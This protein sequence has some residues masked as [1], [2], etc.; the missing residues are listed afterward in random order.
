MTT[1]TAATEQPQGV[2]PASWLARALGFFS[3]TVGLVVK[4]VLLAAMN[5][6]ALYAV[7]VLVADDRWVAGVLVAA[8]TVLVDVIYLGPWHRTVPLKFLVPGTIFLIGFQVI[9]LISNVNIA[10]TNWSTGHNLN[11][12]EAIAAIEENSLTPPPNGATYTMA[13]ARSANGDLVLL[14]VD[15]ETGKHYVGTKEGLTA[16]PASDVTVA[17]GTITSAKGYETVKGQELFTL[18]EEAGKLLVPTGGGAFV[19]AE[20]L[21]QAVEL[22]PTL[23]YV[24]AND[25]FVNLDTKTVYSNNGEGSY[26]SA[27]GD[28]LEPGWKTHVGLKNFRTIFTDPLVRDPFFRVFVWTFVYAAL[29]VFLTFALGLFLAITLNKPDLRLQKLQRALLV[30]P[31]AIPAY[32]SV[33]VW[34]G[35]L[36][37]DFGVVN[38]LFGIHIP[39]LFDPTWAKVSCV[40]VNLW[41]GFPYFFLVCTGAL[42]AIPAELTEAARVDGATS[43]QVFRKV[44][45]PLLLA[46]TA[47]LLIASFAF[48]FNNFNN[49]YLLTG[50]GPLQADQAVA[51]STDILISYTYK[52]AFQAGKGS[53][54]GLAAAV[55][56]V[57]FFIIATISAISFWRTKS[58]ENLA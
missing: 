52:L 6:L 15:E 31:Y 21:S 18:D 4:L 39:W 51:G 29:S 28:V 33:L 38:N 9:P 20:G 47:P 30:I 58:L 25:T 55:S 24:P 1:A 40:L 3:G 17:N 26:E 14:L 46:A 44:T 7:G 37:D 19:R 43:R 34:G 49:I 53:D 42:Q 36:N 10:F 35:L 12:A 13:P 8:A 27:S 2:P 32:L 23:K 54:Y 11:Q 56:I 57:I 50:G 45:L 22:Q 16:L 41:L 5:G 48:N